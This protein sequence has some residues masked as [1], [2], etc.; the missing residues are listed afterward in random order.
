VKG[1]EVAATDVGLTVANPTV[2]RYGEFDYNLAPRLSAL[3]GRKVGLVWNAKANGDVAL[4][5][6]AERIQTVV[7]DV[8]FIFYSGQEPCAS[9]LLEQAIEECDAFI[10]CTAD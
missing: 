8:E 6:A 2:E 4:R 3:S 9:E 5:T 7:P 10:A 1:C